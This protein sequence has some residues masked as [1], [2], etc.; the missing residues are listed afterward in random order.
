MKRSKAVLVVEREIAA[1]WMRGRRI[2]SSEGA[3][4]IGDQIFQHFFSEASLV[5]F[6]KVDKSLH[7]DEMSG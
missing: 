4:C 5:G 7:G 1:L 3:W 6:F 2:F